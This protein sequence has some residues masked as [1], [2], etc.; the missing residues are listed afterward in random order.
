MAGRRVNVAAALLLCA[1]C[2]ER[3]I[4]AQSDA[5][6]AQKPRIGQTDITLAH[7]STFDSKSDRETK[8]ADHYCF[9]KVPPK[10]PACAAVAI[11][12][13]NLPGPTSVKVCRPPSKEPTAVDGAMEAPLLDA[14]EKVKSGRAIV[15]CL[16]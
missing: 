16:P 3:G 12:D 7:L 2:V 1:A 9:S 10:S 14:E 11:R 4:L 5:A 13:P 6:G 15:L 8:W